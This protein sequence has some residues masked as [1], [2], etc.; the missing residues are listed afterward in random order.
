MLH[1]L[2]LVGECAPAMIEQWDRHFTL[3]HKNFK[4]ALHSHQTQTHGMNN[5]VKKKHGNGCCLHYTVR[6]SA[7]G[8]CG[9]PPPSIAHP[10]LAHEWPCLCTVAL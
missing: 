9:P 5:E 8:L 1:L 2:A 10:R 3:T 4:L 7:T 6:W